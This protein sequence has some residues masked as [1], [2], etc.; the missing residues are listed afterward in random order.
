MKITDSVRFTQ[1]N[2]KVKSKRVVCNV[3]GRTE[4]LIVPDVDRPVM[5]DFKLV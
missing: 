1:A 3:G 5:F 2:G 4:L